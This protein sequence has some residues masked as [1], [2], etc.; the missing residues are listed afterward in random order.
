M[1]KLDG[2]E[3]WNSKMLLTE[4]QE[5]YERRNERPRTGLPD[6]EELEM[7]RDSILLP[8]L[9]TML[10][11]SRSE[12]ERL[13]H[14]LKP[15]YLGATDALL[16]R[17][18]QEMRSLRK[19]LARRQIKVTGEEYDGE[20]VYYYSYVC[21]GY[22]DRFGIVREVMRSELSVKLGRYIGDL[23]KALRELGQ[24]APVAQ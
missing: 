21:R 18:A 5:R 16:D 4:H 13:P 9:I 20:M 2:N 1:S 14:L 17:A 10:E 23:N 7:L 6:T 15:A 3:R 12:I 22:T 24:T 11:R 8:H 19:E